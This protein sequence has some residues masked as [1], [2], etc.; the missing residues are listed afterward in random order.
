MPS[1]RVANANRIRIMRA[2]QYADV[3]GDWLH[4]HYKRRIKEKKYPTFAE[5]ARLLTDLRV[6]TPRG[7]TTWQAVQVQRVLRGYRDP[8]GAEERALGIAR[9]GQ[10]VRR[11]HVIIREKAA[12]EWVE[13][14]NDEEH[15]L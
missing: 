11:L 3:V 7:G 8:D 4:R 12:P 10:M 6:P 14:M 9:P 15:D 2:T 1:P 13:I 5:V